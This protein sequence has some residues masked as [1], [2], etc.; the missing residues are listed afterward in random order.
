[1]S[2]PIR[3]VV[4]GKDGTGKAIVVTDSAASRVHTRKELGVTNTLLW[5]T[6]STPAKLSEQGDAGN[7]EV[8]IVPPPNGTIFR[9]IEFGPQKDVQA[10]YQTRLQIFERMG[11][12]PEGTSREMP[13]DPGMHRTRTVDY[14]VVLSGEIDMLLDDSEVHLNAGDV[15]IQRGTNHAWVNRGNEPCKVA[16]VLIDATEQ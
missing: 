1:M 6:D 12:A 7:R 3:R 13:R 5:V 10:D 9:I 11:L 2:F 4:T 16:F 14:V 8:G 15:V